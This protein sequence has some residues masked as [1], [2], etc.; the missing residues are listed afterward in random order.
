MS[1]TQPLVPEAIEGRRELPRVLGL[2]DIGVLASAAMG[3]AY[4]LASTMGPM[5]AAAGNDAVLALA[6]LGLI[7]LGVALSFARL[8]D[9]LPDAGSSFS[10]SA[11]AFGAA[12][13]TYA[14]WLLLL[15]NYFATMTTA[16][17]AATYTLAL[18]A[19]AHASDP[20]WD[21][22]VGTL[23]IA[24]STVLLYYGLRPTAL[25]TALFL[26]GELIVVG[27]AAAASFL[28][29]PAA[30]RLVT[31]AVPLPAAGLGGIVAAMV[32]GIWMTDG[33]EVSASASEESTGPATTSGRGGIVALVLTT[34]VLLGAMAAFLHLGSVAG[35]TAHQS[36]AMAYVASRLGGGAWRFAID[37]TV[38]VSTAATLWTTILYLSR[39]VYAMGRDRVLPA[40]I[41]NLDGRGVPVHSLLL[42][43]VCVAGFTLLTGFWRSANDVLDLVLNGTSV[44][45][46][47]LFFMST[48]SAIKLLANRPGETPLQ[49]YVIPGMSALA[50]AAIVGVDIAESDLKT[51]TIELAGLSLG[52]PF[53]LWR[54][55]RMHLA[56]IFAAPGREPELE[57]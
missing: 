5:V 57:R 16:L 15:S 32:L 35:F 37:A 9:V 6:L 19:P 29:H 17:P 46:G 11:R 31:G 8:S 51:K 13:G 55:R 18:V 21:A 23:W 7:M 4:S 41:G 2:F 36:D 50:L 45:L 1:G 49:A 34:A 43:F 42:V 26:V 28:V 53:S 47:A 30:E 14:A 33:W 44:F 54:G 38:L 39:S 24:A 10:W 52:I 22:V 12:G 27:I 20:L 56:G 25:V 40:A 3:P 48:L